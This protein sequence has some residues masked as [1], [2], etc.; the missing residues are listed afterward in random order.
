MQF[1]RVGS[2]VIDAPGDPGGPQAGGPAGSGA[3]SRIRVTIQAFIRAWIE[4]DRERLRGLSTPDI[5]ISWT[6]FDGGPVT[7]RGLDEVLVTGREFEERFGRAVRYTMVDTMGGAQHG[8]I[9]FEP[10]ELGIETDRVARVAVYRIE[11]GRVAAVTVY[12]DQAD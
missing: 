10:A 12:L 7:A 6:G 8:A 2:S 9:L 4:D 11:D 5:A 3:A 1:R